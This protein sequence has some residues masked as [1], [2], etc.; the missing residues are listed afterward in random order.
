MDPVMRLDRLTWVEYEELV[1]IRPVIIPIGATEQHGHHL[2][3]GTDALCVTRV[4]EAV[5]QRCGALV[6]P[7]LAYGY[8][9]IPRSGGGEE[10]P[11]TTGLSLDLVVRTVGEL[12]G[13]FADD[14]ARLVCVMSGHYENRIP[15]HEAC[16]LFTRGRSDVTVLNM[17]WADFLTEET[18]TGVY[19]AGIDYPG[20]ELEHAAF[21]ETSLMLHLY[22]D[23]VGTYDENQPLA[24]FAP[25]DQHPTPPGTVPATGA[26]APSTGATAAAGERVFDECVDGIAAALTA[27]SQHR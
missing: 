1:P 24:A 10:F 25:Y 21:L 2:P 5:S 19:P 18:L 3:L 14:G 17:L 9:S 8:R 4:A 7:T 12:L 16:H 27:L 26:L 15:L 11:G 22:P 6:A 23:L 13:Q 20:V